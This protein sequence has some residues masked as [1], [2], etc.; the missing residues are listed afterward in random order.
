MVQPRRTVVIGFL[1]TQLD[2]GRGPKRWHHWR[3]TVSLGQLEDLLVDRVELL[4]PTS[5]Q[6]LAD[7]VAADLASA[8]PATTVRQHRFDV[9]DP[10]DL[11]EVYAGLLDFAERYPFDTAREDYLVHITTGTHIGQ[12]CMFLLSEARFFPARLVQTSPPARGESAPRHV[13]IDLDLSKYDQLAA[14][15]AKRQKDGLALLKSGIDTRNRTFNALVAELERVALV[16]SDPILLTGPTGSGKSQLAK[17]VVALKRAR[18]QLDGPLVEVNCA[19]LRGDGAMS[20]LFGHVRGAFTGAAGA[21]AGLLAKADGGVLF[22]DEIGELGLDEQAM[23]LRAIE[24]RVFYPVGSDQEV[25]SSFQL[26]AGTNRE[27]GVEV[28]AGRFREDLYSRI[29][30]WTFRLPGLRERPEDLA[31]N[32]AYELE[33]AAHALNQRITMS[34]EAQDAYLAFGTGRGATWAGNFR[35]LGASV[36]R[37]ATLADGGR[38]GVADVRQEIERLRAAWDRVGRRAELAADRV[39]QLLGQ[40]AEDLDRFDRVQLDDVIAVCR[41]AASLSEAGRVLFAASRK[42]K[43][44]SNDA[45]RLRK[46][47]ARFGLDWAAV[48][49][50]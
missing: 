31:P 3:P 16:S 45:D 5:H 38:I 40:K 30:L 14:R 13:V 27:L 36:R 17:Q 42:S 28:A 6:A 10:W 4:F 43:T 12:I 44:S 24:E 37:M 18:H 19:T 8:S 26:I 29:N 46:Y 41:D 33:R 1:G 48:A 23:L 20:A 49:P 35:D 34:R 11:A 32:L 50:R 39:S 47:L 2:G 9:R 25:R 7:I 21:R 15:S 22:L